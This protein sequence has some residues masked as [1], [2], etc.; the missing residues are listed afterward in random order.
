MKVIIYIYLFVLILDLV[1]GCEM[2]NNPVE[3]IS[4]V[5]SD[6]VAKSRDTLMIGCDAHD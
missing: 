4:L 1:S 2:K 6:T 5:A 3:I